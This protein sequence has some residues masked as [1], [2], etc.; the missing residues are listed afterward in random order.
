MIFECVPA[1]HILRSETFYQML[2]LVFHLYSQTGA[3]ERKQNISGRW[4]FEYTED[5]STWNAISGTGVGIDMKFST[6]D[7]ITNRTTAIRCT[8]R[9]S[10]GVIL[11]MLSVSVLADAEVT[12]EAVFNALTDN[13]DRQLIAYGSDGKLYINGEYIKSKT[14]RP[15]LST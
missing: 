9:N 5:G 13:G 1:Y 7:R 10:S 11:G 4:T 15:I 2:P 12:R 3:E 8:V 6:W 14:K